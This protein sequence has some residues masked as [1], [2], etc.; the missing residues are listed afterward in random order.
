MAKA[1]IQIMRDLRVHQTANAAFL[2]NESLP[3]RLEKNC[4]N[5][6]LVEAGIH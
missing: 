1:I 4:R 5:A 2:I 6:E 3:V